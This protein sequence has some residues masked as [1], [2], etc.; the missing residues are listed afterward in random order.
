MRRGLGHP[1][2]PPTPRQADEPIS[3]SELTRTIKSLLE[4]SVGTVAVEGEVTGLKPSPSG[5]I[6]FCLKD[7]QALV[8][9]VIWRSAAGRLRQLPQNGSKI[10]ARG[11]LTVYEPRG[12]YQLVVTSIASDAGKGDLWQKFEELKQK[13]AEE[14]L[15]APERKR[16]LPESPKTIGIVTSPHAAALR[17]IL[18]ILSRR[19]PN[20]RVV[21]S[22]CQVQG[23]DAAPDI[24]F[25]LKRMDRWGGADV[26]IVGRGGGSLEDLWPFNEEVVARAIANMSVPVVSAVGHETDFT[27]A[28][29]VS[30]A[31]AATPSE[32]AECI[33][34]DQRQMRGR[35]NHTAM[36]LSRA[37][38]GLVRE[39]KHQLSSVARCQLY[40]R[41]MDM[42]QNRWQR[43]DDTAESMRSSMQIC[44]SQSNR[45]IDVLHARMG[46]LSPLAVLSRGYAV[47]QGPD[48][49]AILNADQVK[50][51]DA[52]RALVHEGAI[53]AIVAGND[54]EQVQKKPKPKKSAADESGRLF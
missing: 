19:A 28:D 34:P 31:R 44:L 26:V 45:R 47:V 50:P 10:V 16:S 4:G 32:A 2:R 42:F 18:K 35:I 49:K 48:G 38:S 27:I 46:G 36:V 3:V 22:P 43:L 7:S 20:L 25:A 6:Y 17:D 33:A 54:G 11:K 40:R 12:R 15:F 52:I 14:G 51:G 13:L 8:D 29:F 37:L 53:N 1:T 30:D 41:P 24:A 23:K 9:C 21:V 39:R 5:H